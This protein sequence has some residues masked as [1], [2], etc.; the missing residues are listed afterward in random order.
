MLEVEN[1]L[2]VKSF[3]KIGW[4]GTRIDF[5]QSRHNLTILEVILKESIGL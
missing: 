2:F 5:L 3:I 1:D 4:L